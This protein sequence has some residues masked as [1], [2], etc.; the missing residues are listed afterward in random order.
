MGRMKDYMMELADA[1]GV[2]FEEITQA[3]L[4]R[5]FMEKAQ[6][7]FSNSET[8]E[9]ELEKWK[10]YLPVKSYDEVKF[11]DSEAGNPKFKV[12]SVLVDNGVFYLVK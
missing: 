4:E 10:D 5:D 9:S 7:A 2:T 12:G 1:K 3:D 6:A 8:P 11:Y